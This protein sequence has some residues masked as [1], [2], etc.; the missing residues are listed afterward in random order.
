MALQFC[1]FGCLK[2]VFSANIMAGFEW[3]FVFQQLKS[4]YI[5]IKYLL[6]YVHST[7]G[8]FVYKTAS[9][10][11]IR[12]WVK[13]FIFFGKI[14]LFRLEIYLLINLYV[15]SLE[16]VQI[17]FTWKEI[18]LKKTAIIISA[19]NDILLK[20]KIWQIHTGCGS[21]TKN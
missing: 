11:L 15:F 12:F 13:C 18:V 10:N 17:L 19:Y 20:I 16:I 2:F 4:Y 9:A 14:F 6:H 5:N 7:Y 21:E 1:M 3:N 8:I